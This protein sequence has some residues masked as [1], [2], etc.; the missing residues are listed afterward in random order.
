[1]LVMGDLNFS[2]AAAHAPGRKVGALIFGLC[3]W[4]V[5]SAVTAHHQLKW[6]LQL[7]KIATTIAKTVILNVTI[8]VEKPR[9]R[10]GS[11]TSMKAS[12]MLASPPLRPLKA[13]FS[14]GTSDIAAH[15]VS[16]QPPA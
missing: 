13:W 12:S 4:P 14:N 8:I 10:A 5:C 15:T 11:V 3:R 9:R 1:M 2:R 16:A 7:V 6:W